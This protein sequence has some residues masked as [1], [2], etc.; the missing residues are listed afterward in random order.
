MTKG[1]VIFAALA[2]AVGIGG[3]FAFK[4]SKFNP[5]NLYYKT[6]ASGNPCVTAP[7]QNTNSALG[8]CTNPSNF[9]AGYYTESACTTSTVT[10]YAT[11]AQ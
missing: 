6:T 9:F 3:A 8:T 7:C 10:G 1:K 4:A 11:N 5:R 2:F